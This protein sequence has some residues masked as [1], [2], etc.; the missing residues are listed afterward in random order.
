MTADRKKICIIDDDSAMRDS[1]SMLLDLKGFSVDC[2]SS[3]QQFLSRRPQTLPT[4]LL[5]DVNMPEISGVELLERLKGSGF[6]APC[7]MMTGQGQVATAVRAMKAG[8]SDF[9]EKPFDETSLLDV[10]A[11]AMTQTGGDHVSERNDEAKARVSRL[12]PRERDVFV[13]ISRGQPNKLIAHHLGIS[14]RTVEIHRARL[15]D[16]LSAG[17][18]AEVVRLAVDAGLAQLSAGDPKPGAK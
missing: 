13:Q 10:I 12:T 17:S 9:I 5:I 2:F 8:A 14:P 6:E 3:A 16:K 11:R 1:L 7:I 18:V 4:C 15:M